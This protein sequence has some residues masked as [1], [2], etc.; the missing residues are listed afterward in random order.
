VWERVAVLVEKYNSPKR[1]G[2]KRSDERAALNGLLHVGG[3]GCQWNESPTKFGDNSSVH[4]AM[5]RGA[6]CDLFAHLWALL[7]SGC[8]ELNDIG[9][10]SQSAEGA[11]GEA[12]R[13][14]TPSGASKPHG[15]DSI[16]VLSPS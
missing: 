11:M 7:L 6:E 15:F 10:K 13:V 3:T 14:V 2:P 5:R 16:V 4:R 8:D 9:W 12:H 1:T